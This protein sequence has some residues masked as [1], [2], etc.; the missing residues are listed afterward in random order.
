M[1]AKFIEITVQNYN[2]LHGF[3]EQN[4]EIEEYVE[5]SEPV[6]KLVNVERIL[7][8]SEK[9]ILISYAYNRAIY[10]EYLDD[11]QTVMEKLS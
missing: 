3:D 11:Y 4:K 1:S 8:V 9:F 7:S 5:V 6:K 10:W 2:V